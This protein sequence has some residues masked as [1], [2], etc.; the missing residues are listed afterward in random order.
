MK[1]LSAK[2]KLGSLD[3]Q[4]FTHTHGDL[5]KFWPRKLYITGIQLLAD[6]R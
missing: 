2:W 3:V 1:F 5:R 4:M 6:Y